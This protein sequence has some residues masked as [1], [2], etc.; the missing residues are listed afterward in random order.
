MQQ[1][2]SQI[3]S[4]ILSVCIGSPKWKDVIFVL[5]ISQRLGILSSNG[6]VSGFGGGGEKAS[7]E[8][9]TFDLIYICS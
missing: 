6:S 5:L 3:S 8:G 9:N 4:L 1:L 7:E 2:E